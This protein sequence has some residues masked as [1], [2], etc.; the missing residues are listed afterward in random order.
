VS[1]SDDP[2]NQFRMG[3]DI[4]SDQKESGFDVARFEHVEEAWRV[5][6]TVC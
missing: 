3:L 5:T 2:S 1:F 4:L 6:E